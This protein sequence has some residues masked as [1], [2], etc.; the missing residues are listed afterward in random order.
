M[1]LLLGSLAFT[2]MSVVLYVPSAM[3]NPVQWTAA[4]GGN[5]H[6]Y[7]VVDVD[8]C[9]FSWDRARAAASDPC[10]Q[11]LRGH[12]VTVTSQAETDFLV[13]SFG[14]SMSNKWMGGFQ[15]PPGPE[16]DPAA[17]WEWI[18]GETWSYTNWGGNEPSNSGGDENYLEF[19][20][21]PNPGDWNDDKLDGFTVGYVIEYEGDCDPV[22]VESSTWGSIKAVYR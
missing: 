5:D 7:E 2:L 20:D 21:N 12:L 4:T 1:F 18:T 19:R 10:F 13:S 16:V 9:S 22:Q 11:G 14:A 15:T 3:A 8:C 6:W 17:D